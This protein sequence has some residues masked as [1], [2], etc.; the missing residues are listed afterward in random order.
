MDNTSV[1]SR[2]TTAPLPAGDWAMLGLL[3]LLWGGSFFFY[4]ILAPIFPPFTRGGPHFSD[5][6]LS[7]TPT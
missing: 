4:K 5:R 2:H 7:Y 3:S 6:W 1:I